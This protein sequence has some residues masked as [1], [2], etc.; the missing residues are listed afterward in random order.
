[1]F[2]KIPSVIWLN[3][4][5]SDIPDNKVSVCHHGVEVLATSGTDGAISPQE[6]YILFVGGR[7][8]HKN[9]QSLLAAV[10]LSRQLKADFRIV[11]FGGRSFSGAEREQILKLGFSQDQ[12]VQISGDDALL[13]AHYKNA[14][15][16][17]YPS[18]YEGFGL[19]PLEAMAQDCP[20]VSS[21]TSSLPEVIGDAAEV[22]NPA[23]VDDIS[24][25]IQS[26]VYS[27]E[28]QEQLI[29]KGRKRV[30]LFTWEKCAQQ[31]MSIYNK[32]K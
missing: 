28:Y 8:G 23:S 29:I 6:P 12:V 24:R 11:A 7:K 21:N 30:K 27:S 4:L 22:F 20:V 1:V 25:A 32:L 14:S 2:R 31:T 9:F 16:F 17:V 15:A 26:V 5:I 10:A 13:R 18:H 3:C 19:P